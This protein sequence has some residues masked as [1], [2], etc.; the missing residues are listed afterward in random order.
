MAVDYLSTLNVGSGLN[1][2]EIIDALVDAERAPQENKISKQREQRTVQISSLGQVK[3]GFESLDT[4]LAPADG[5][6]GLVAS[7][8]GT[9]LDIEIDD[10]AAAKAFSHNLTIDSIAAA[11]TLVFDGH[12]GETATVGTGSLTLSFGSWADD[13]TFSTNADRSDL[14]VEITSDNNSLAGLRDAINAA[15][16]DVNAT[17]LKTGSSSYALVVKSREGAAHAMR[18]TASEDAG[19]A[20]LADFAYTAVD[21]DV[22]TVAAADAALKLDGTT[23]SR[24]TNEITDLLDGMKLTLKS[25]TSTASLVTAEYDTATASAAMQLILEGINSMGDILKQM[26]QRGGNGSEEGPLAGDPLI[27][28]LR[29]QLGS[30]TTMAIPG[31]KD[32]SVYL[33]DFGAKTERDGTITL[34][35]EAFKKAYEADPERF[36]AITNS[37]IVSSSGLVTPSVI[38]GPPKPGVYSFDIADDGSATIND[39]AMSLFGTT[40]SIATGDAAGLRLKKI[41][42]G[43]DAN[44]YVGKSLLESLSDFTKD[45]LALDGDLDL[46][47]NRYNEDLAGYES[48]LMALDSRIEAL[49]ARHVKQ[50]TMME[51]AVSSLKE[52]GKSLDNMMEAWKASQQR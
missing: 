8:T 41:G 39:E 37:Q 47:I 52:T 30:F 13:G 40:Y 7:R 49:R 51:S 22:E 24:E 23:I 9:A 38:G 1:T 10:A 27:R 36:A 19:A 31:F 50:F 20:G 42:D 18:I 28:T 46:K 26:G 17:I 29:R 34:D 4:G 14:T 48:D 45:V 44:I 16:D 32:E 6:T 35:E 25:T 3:Q 5:L 2:S 33:A 12:S 43:A 15:S 21:T 11:H